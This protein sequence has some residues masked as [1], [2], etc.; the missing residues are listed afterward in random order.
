MMVIPGTIDDCCSDTIQYIRLYT[1]VRSQYST[2]R[3]DSIHW[4]H[5]SAGNSTW[6]SIDISYNSEGGMSI[7]SIQWYLDWPEGRFS[8]RRRVLFSSYSEEWRSRGR[9]WYS[10]GLLSDSFPAFDW[11]LRILSWY[12]WNRKWWCVIQ[13]RRSLRCRYSLLID[14]PSG[15]CCSGQAVDMTLSVLMIYSI[16][17]GKYSFDWWKISFDIQPVVEDGEEYSFRFRAIPHHWRYGGDDSIGEAWYWRYGIC[18]RFPLMPTTWPEVL[19]ILQFPNILL[20][21]ESDR[22]LTFLPVIHYDR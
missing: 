8:I 16:R 15:M 10:E 18:S 22:Q 21:G 5:Y 17:Y 14:I 9:K 19:P 3:T 13:F 6:W 11:Y 12:W 20:V 4:R 2:C 7:H 1:V